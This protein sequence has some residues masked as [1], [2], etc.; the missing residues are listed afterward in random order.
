M[1]GSEPQNGNTENK[2]PDSP[3]HGSFRLIKLRLGVGFRMDFLFAVGKNTRFSTASALS[4]A[5]SA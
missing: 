1:Q 3:G 4:L 5:G 2:K